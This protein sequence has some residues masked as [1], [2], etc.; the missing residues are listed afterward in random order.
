M[1]SDVT[2]VVAITLTVEQW[3]KVLEALQELPAKIANP[4]N[5]LIV[6]QAQEQLKVIDQVLSK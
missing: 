4:I 2:K 6:N 5:N 1:G 3:N